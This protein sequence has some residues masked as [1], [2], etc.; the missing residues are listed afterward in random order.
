MLIQPALVIFCNG[1][2]N[3]ENVS[4]VK[5]MVIIVSVAKID[6]FISCSGFVDDASPCCLVCGLGRVRVLEP[7]LK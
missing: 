2:G 7:G 1:G 5:V 3:G 6:E 4:V